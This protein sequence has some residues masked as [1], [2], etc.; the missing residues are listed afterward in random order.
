MPPPIMKGRVHANDHALLNSLS[1]EHS[2]QQSTRKASPQKLQALDRLS[3]AR[4]AEAA[5]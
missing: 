3:A 5:R 1:P 2:R 4:I